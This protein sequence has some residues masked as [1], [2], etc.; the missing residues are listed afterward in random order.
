M[1]VFYSAGLRSVPVQAPPGEDVVVRSGDTVVHDFA[2]PA[3]YV[4][5]GASPAEIINGGLYAGTMP[6]PFLRHTSS[7]AGSTKTLQGPLPVGPITINLIRAELSPNG[8]IPAPPPGSL[9]V[10]TGATTDD[11]IETRQDGSLLNVSDT[12]ETIYALVLQLSGE[13]PLMP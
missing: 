11:S 2:F 5:H 8:V 6:S 3:A 9:M 4:N 7:L 10:E 12:T 1:E 13:P